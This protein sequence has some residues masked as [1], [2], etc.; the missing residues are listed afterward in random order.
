M[1]EFVR[2]DSVDVADVE[3]LWAQYVPSA[4]AQHIDPERFEFRWRSAQTNGLTVVRYALTAT[5]SAVVRPEDQILACR[6]AT[7]SGWV[8]SARTSLETDLPWVTDG[9]QV[10]AFWERTADVTAFVF[11]RAMAE[12][13]ARR[14]TGDDA[15]KLR[16]IDTAPRN[17]TVGRHWNRTFDHVFH[18]LAASGEDR[19]IEVSL[20]RHALITT[21]STFYSTYFDAAMREPRF[22]GASVVRRAIAY[23]D[24]HAH[25]PITV[26]DVA[27]AAHISA[28]GLQY[29]FRRALDITPAAYLRSVRLDGAHRDLR[30]S[31]PDG[32]VTE[33]ARRWGFANTSRFG[34]AYREVYGVSPQQ[35]LED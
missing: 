6:I 1:A 3:R 21:L 24:A 26:G 12:N 10:E 4:R 15:L 23:M 29:A 31:A 19:L 33:I 14:I 16:L 13:L 5:V 32:S 22:V 7:D 11:D 28:R 25:E 27:V 20:V 35:T 8:R 18:A 34:S 17:E 2:V 9:V 30:N